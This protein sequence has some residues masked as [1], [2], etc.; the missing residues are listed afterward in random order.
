MTISRQKPYNDLTP[1]PPD[2]ALFETIEVYKKLTEA[3]TAL[4]ELKGRLPIIPNPMMLINTLVLQEARASSEIENVLT[5][6]DKMYRAFT[7]NKSNIDPATKEV[8]RYREALW[9]AFESQHN[10]KNID[11][12][13]RIFRTITQRDESIRN[14]QVYVGNAYE[15]IYTPPQS[16]L[17][18]DKLINWLDFFHSNN[19]IDPLIKMAIL[20][21]QFEAIHPFGDGNG[22]TGRIFNVLYLTDKNLIELPILYISKHILEHKNEYYQLL[23]DVTENQNWQAWILFMLE[24]VH[25]TSI[26]TLEKVNAIYH[27]FNDVKNYVRKNAENIY[28]RELIEV[29]FSQI[30]CKNKTLVEQKI[31]SRNTASK[32]LNKLVEMGILKIHKEGKETL[33]LNKQLYDILVKS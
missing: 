3:S 31:A 16:N 23:S 4:A 24:A 12:I 14:K 20:H 9:L 2:K 8:L 17:L 21:Y 10:T 25:R 5:T 13:V 26:F 19:E 30:Y 33:Y 28:S 1:I 27:L 22:R 11:W 29:L 18:S 32:Y 15:I 7:A 6:A